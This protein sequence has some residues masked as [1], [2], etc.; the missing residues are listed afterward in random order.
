M[1]ATSIPTPAAPVTAPSETDQRIIF[2]DVTWSEFEVMLAIRG[3]RAGIRMIYLNGELELMS[4]SVDHEGVKT[5]IARLL[6]IHALETGIPLNGF[7]SWTLKNPLRARAIEPDECY[8]VGPGRPSRPDLAIEVIWTSGGLDK[9]E[10]YR[11]LGVGEVWLW[12]H[13]TI[14]VYVL[15][16]EQ[17]ER[18]QRSVV[19]P[20]L[21]AL[22][23]HIE[24]EN[25][26]DAVRRYRDTLRRGA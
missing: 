2:P 26:T 23:R 20:D 24:P 15:A 1:S 14:E 25:Q 10:V 6:E 13:G 21:E 4:P 12:R 5:V 3:D 22:A 8:S 18:R 16:A 9:L 17:Y 11:G 19:F 7:G